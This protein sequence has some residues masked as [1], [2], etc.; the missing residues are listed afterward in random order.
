MSKILTTS[1]AEICGASM[2]AAQQRFKSRRET[3]FS[4][5]QAAISKACRAYFPDQPT[6]QNEMARNV[7]CAAADAAYAA[8]MSESEQL[9]KEDRAE[10][11][12]KL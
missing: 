9:L 11:V 12:A 5:K 4:E 1:A 7:A 8:A 3:A 2:M 10:A 6:L